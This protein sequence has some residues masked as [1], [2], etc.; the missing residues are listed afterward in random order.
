MCPIWNN[1]LDGNLENY[2]KVM[3][4]K[5]L[6]DVITLLNL[7]PEKIIDLVSQRNLKESL[8][9]EL[10]T[11]IY[12][13]GRPSETTLETSPKHLLV[14][15]QKIEKTL[16]KAIEIIDEIETN[17]LSPDWLKTREMIVADL[18]KDKSNNHHLFINEVKNVK[19][20][21]GEILT[22]TNSAVNDIT[23]TIQK[24]GVSKPSKDMHD[25]LILE[26][27][28]VYKRYTGKKPISWNTGTDSMNP[29]QFTGDILYFLQG[30]LSNSFYSNDITF[31][32]LQKKIIRLKDSQKNHDLW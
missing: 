26:L 11:I 19:K 3:S 5:S 2:N 10:A 8:W 31:G 28:K 20:S 1:Y 29:N 18:I 7:D 32:A 13:W 24:R 21:L 9:R 30:V 12:T 15:M 25:R 23:P 4:E 14:H 17:V 16:S 27:C 6:D 22:Y